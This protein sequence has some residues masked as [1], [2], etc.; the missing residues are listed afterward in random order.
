MLSKNAFEEA[1]SEF[2]IRLK[3]FSLTQEKVE[4]A[5]DEE[6]LMADVEASGAYQDGMAAIKGKLQC[7]Q[8]STQCLIT[9]NIL[10]F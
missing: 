2:Y 3:A 8:R 9:L 5:L 4:E 1:I 7:F 10:I 6:Q